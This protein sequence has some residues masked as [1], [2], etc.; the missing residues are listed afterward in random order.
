MTVFRLFSFLTTLYLLLF[1]VDVNTFQL[2][3]R[4]F[5]DQLNSELLEEEEDAE[6][7]TKLEGDE[8]EFCSS[9][10]VLDCLSLSELWHFKIRNS[11]K[12]W[13]SQTDIQFFSPPPEA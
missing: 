5:S 9:S 3:S 8:K 12:I 4:L 11:D 7:K 10:C 1:I 6:G 13:A 2:S